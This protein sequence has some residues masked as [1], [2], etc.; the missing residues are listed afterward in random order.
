MKH[1]PDLNVPKYNNSFNCEKDQD[2]TSHGRCEKHNVLNHFP[3]LCKRDIS[4]PGW[5]G[6]TS[7]RRDDVDARSDGESTT[8]GSY[9][10]D[11]NVFAC[12]DVHAGPEV[13][14]DVFV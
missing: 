14:S 9:F 5:A 11:N 2:V 3:E 8:S 4:L 13:S 1:F 12:D 7:S 6:V 10:V